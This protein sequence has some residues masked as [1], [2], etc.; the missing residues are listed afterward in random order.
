[1]NATSRNADEGRPLGPIAYLIPEFPGVTHNWLWREVTHMREWSADVRLFSTRPPDERSAAPHAFANEARGE[2]TYLLPRP[3]SSILASVVW[4]ALRRPLGF[5]KAAIIPLT[6]DGMSLR[7]RAA[8]LALLV[9]ASIFARETTSRGIQHVHAHSAGR[10]A[11]IAMMTRRL[12]GLR[13][14]LTLHGDLDWWGG[15]MESKLRDAEFTIVVAEWLREQVLE[16]YPSLPPSTI[17]R[18]H[19]GV[20]TRTWVPGEARPEDSA[21]RLV[22]VARLHLG[23]GHDVLMKAVA[24]L[25]QTERNVVLRVVGSGPERTELESVV[26]DLGLG[27]AVEFTGSL[28][29][30]E[31]IACLRLADAFVLASNSDTRPV[32]IMEAMA[33]GL[34]VVGADAGGIPEIITPE[35]D[36]LLFSADDA[37]GLAEA[38]ARLMD[39]SELRNRF[40]QTARRTAVER[41]DSRIGAAVLYE[42]LFCAEPPADL[43]AASL[44]VASQ[45]AGR[46]AM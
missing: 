24:R 38:V 18:G 39:E 20:D 26:R 44:T 19:M 3:S 17:L 42:A 33:L 8:T 23:K 4:A 13:F 9:P 32:V 40:G 30:D 14:S 16:R 15:G 6:L 34:P 22:T 36:G 46:T 35:L 11:V 12:I 45:E 1:M 10:A 28:S 43:S 31:V 25:R 2:T 5:A 37:V 41:F 27:D 21:F 7:E 29:E